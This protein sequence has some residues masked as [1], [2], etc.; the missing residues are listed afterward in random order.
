MIEPHMILAILSLQKAC[1]RS[2]SPKDE[3]AFYQQYQEPVYQR[4]YR[5]GS[6]LAA[7]LR[8]LLRPR[9]N[10]AAADHPVLSVQSCRGMQKSPVA[11]TGLSNSFG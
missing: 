6:R 10:A 5:A 4:L 9:E 7:K 3:D 1:E 8:G 11:S 2:A